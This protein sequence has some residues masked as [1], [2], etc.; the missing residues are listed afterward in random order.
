MKLLK[1]IFQEKEIRNRILFTIGIL[2]IY[3]IGCAIPVPG[4]DSDLLMSGV[5]ATSI[6]SLMNLLGGGSFEKMSIFALGVSPYITASII[7]ELLSMD[8]I[9]ALTDMAKDGHK[10]REKL[11]K[12]T[13]YLGLVL[14]FI[15]AI[16]IT[17]GFDRQY[18]IMMNRSFGNFLFVSMILAAGVEILIWLGDRIT[19]YG[20]GNGLSMIIFA[21]IVSN[22]PSSFVTTYMTLSGSETTSSVFLGIVKFVLYVAA[23]LTLIL[24]VV[25][26]ELAKRRVP[27]AYSTRTSNMGGKPQGSY[28]PF[29]INSAGVIPVIFASSVLT[30]PQIALSFINHDAY[31]KVSGFLSLQ[32]PFGLILYA[33]LTFFFT[34]FYTELQIDPE[35]TAKNLA[36]SQA[37][38]PGIRP[39]KETALYLKKVLRRITLFGATGLTILATI[40]YLLP[41][42][43]KSLPSSVS[44][45]GTGIILIVGISL[46]TIKQLSG[47][48]ASKGTRYSW[49]F[50]REQNVFQ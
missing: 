34:F 27:I 49:M 43:I 33:V 48:V 45:G 26:V 37:F 5:G 9:P 25:Y 16:S 22:I 12:I 47:M 8:V 11:T 23:Y 3:R 18:G 20:V 17:V 50:N 1:E 13:R 46:E 15:Q 41:M 31:T 6:F 35:E 2:F 39:G 19:A 28:L 32:K 42:L 38:I 7:I 24:A 40:P 14:A 29:K 21:G 30:A 4:I 44:L 36:K 10:G